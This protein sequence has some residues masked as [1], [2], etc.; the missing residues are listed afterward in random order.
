V[1]LRVET[2][3]VRRRTTLLSRYV[4]EELQVELWSGHYSQV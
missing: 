1:E 4:D 2:W 3:P